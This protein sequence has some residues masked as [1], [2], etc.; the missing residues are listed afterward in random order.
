MK[1]ESL[2]VLPTILLAIVIVLL[3]SYLFA[4]FPIGS[5]V[6]HRARKAACLSHLKQFAMGIN[7]YTQ[8]YD[9]RMPRTDNWSG[10]MRLYIKDIDAQTYVC[11]ENINLKC[12]YSF[13]EKLDGICLKQVIDKSKTPMMFDTDLGWNSKST[14]DKAIARHEGGFSCSFV[15][16]HAKIQYP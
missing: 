5:P 3:A 9:N 6:R 11:P 10:V 8:D 16:G 2:Y 1:S 15:D 14:P 7:L 12:G 4:I 13:Y